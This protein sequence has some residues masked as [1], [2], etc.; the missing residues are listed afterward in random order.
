MKIKLSVI[1]KFIGLASIMALGIIPITGCWVGSGGKSDDPTN[2]WTVTATAATW[3]TTNPYGNK[4]DGGW[5]YSA[6]EDLLYAMY[7]DDNLGQTL[8]RIDHIG[9]TS[10]TATTFLFGRH[11]SNP[12][13]DNTGT[14]VYM[15][16]SENTDELER[17]NTVTDVLET[18][19]PA[20][21]GGQFSQGAWKDGKLWIVLEDG[22]LYSYDPGADTW[23]GSLY[24]F[25]TS[26]GNVA[27]SGPRSDLI[28]IIV[29]PGD[30]YS[31]D[32]TT[33]TTTMLTSHLTG[34]VLDGNGQFTWFGSSVGFIYAAAENGIPAIYDI[35]TGDWNALS[36]PKING[37]YAGHATYDYIRMRLYVT[38]SG[39]SNDDVWYYQY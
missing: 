28:Y 4:H 31:Y 1:I 36:D 8:Y 27:T 5:V 35:A 10:E 19:A 14:Y 37:D 2:P 12:V 24:D 38:G 21:Y 18:L 20:P 39:S 22:D 30:F 13:I 7:G 3:L 9:E 6:D 15:P 16:P 17:Y 11:G 23:S 32:V 29:E 33:D 34:F 25:G 26:Y